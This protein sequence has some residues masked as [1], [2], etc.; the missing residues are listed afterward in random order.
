[1][2]LDWRLS[3]EPALQLKTWN[4]RALQ[5]GNSYEGCNLER[6][7]PRKSLP[8]PP[9]QKVLP[10]RRPRHMWE[11]VSPNLRTLS[12]AHIDVKWSGTWDNVRLWPS[13]VHCSTIAGSSRNN[14]KNKNVRIRK[15]WRQKMK[16]NE[17]SFCNILLFLSLLRSFIYLFLL[18]NKIEKFNFLRGEPYLLKINK[19]SF[20]RWQTCYGLTIVEQWRGRILGIIT[21][22]DPSVGKSNRLHVDIL[23]FSFINLGYYIL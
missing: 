11:G 4:L 19:H 7:A 12:T 2:G 18:K 1:M 23:R 20:A 13:M 10:C 16:T 9:L 3:F 17:I 22:W 21:G 5:N 14:Y 6:C 15:L 8:S